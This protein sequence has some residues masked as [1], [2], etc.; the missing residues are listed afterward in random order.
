VRCNVTL[1]SHATDHRLRLRFPTGAPIN[2]FD[3]ATTFDAA[4]RTTKPPDDTGWVH[5]APHTFP[6]QGWIAANGLVVGA[7]GLPE[8]EVT[9]EGDIMIT[10]VRAVG[11]LA[12]LSL[13]TRPM[14]A[15]PDMPAPGAQCPGTIRATITIAKT[16]RDA[17]AAEIGLWGVFGD[18]APPSMLELDSERCELS[19]CKP[20]EDG[21]GII[22][23]VLNP[24]DE[25]DQAH[26]RFGFA[27]DDVAP[28]RL[29]EQPVDQGD[30]RTVPPHALRTVRIRPS[31][32]TT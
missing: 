8:A 3:A 18:S 28:V 5:P 23:R 1:D 26:L 12:K 20:A 14:P 6:H 30:P 4:R 13:R 32:G 19:A 16:P 17:R 29:D 24:T 22:V 11:S 31:S 10:L 7:P 27:V 25:P 21:D 2:E 15:A 9:P